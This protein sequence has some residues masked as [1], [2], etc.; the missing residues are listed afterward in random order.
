MLLMPGA[1]IAG[2]PLR[3][4]GR[5]PTPTLRIARSLALVLTA[6]LCAAPAPAEVK[7]ERFLRDPASIPAV[8]DLVRAGLDRSAHGDLDG[9]ETAWNEIRQFHPEHPAGPIYEIHTL[10]AKRTLDFQDSRYEKAIDQRTR[11]ALELAGRWLERAPDDPEAHFYAGQAKYHQMLQ[12]GLA[13]RYYRAGTAGE[14]GRA[15]LERALALDP[16]LVDAKL[17]LGSY[18]YWASIA[19]RF[20]RFLSWLW[21]VPTGNHDLGI[22]YVRDVS[23]RGRLFRFDAAVQLASFYLYFEETPERA[24]PILLRLQEQYPDN[25]YV[26]FEVAELRLIQGDY[27]ETIAQA[28]AIERSTGRQFGDE[29]RRVMAKIWR[30]R[31]ELLRA[32]PDPAAEV[33]AELSSEWERLSPW[34]RR[35][36]LLTEGHLRDVRGER[37]AAVDHYERVLELE[38][39]FDSGR[40]VTL[41]RQGI[42]TPFR[43]VRPT[44]GAR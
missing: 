41:A 43:P 2:P 18:Y 1:T 23:E 42:E 22:A 4:A 33:L 10:H 21:F 5:L 20:I 26:A 32:N 24:E 29:E 11:E 44:V 38:S 27:E 17:P 31:A 3:A 12:A 6:A 39:R 36:L 34:G 25:S 30:A 19:T 16:G 14:E 9:A 7:S 28:L 15:H 37:T 35:W 13:G 40:A 8:D